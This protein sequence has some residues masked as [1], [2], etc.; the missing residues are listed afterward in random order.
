MQPHV[1]QGYKGPSGGSSSV[2]HKLQ[3]APVP[4][5]NI[6]QHQQ[7][8]HHLSFYTSR[9]QMSSLAALKLQ[10]TP[11]QVLELHNCPDFFCSFHLT[12]SKACICPVLLRSRQS[13]HSIIHTSTP[14]RLFSPSWSC[15]FAFEV[16]YWYYFWCF[17]GI[18]MW[19]FF[20]P[21]VLSDQP[22]IHAWD[23]ANT[24]LVNK[25]IVKKI[26]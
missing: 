15:P 24:E 22:H 5:T 9:R 21:I 20:V 3:I 14:M 17:L 8:N 23:D 6:Y 11:V 25:L 16:A 10:D 2:V 13:P 18:S 1:Q 4:S 19:V 26:I 12:L 7:I